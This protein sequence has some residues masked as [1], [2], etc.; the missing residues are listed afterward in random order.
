MHR[1]HCLVSGMVEAEQCVAEQVAG[2]CLNQVLAVVNNQ[3][4]FFSEDDEPVA[5][6]AVD[7]VVFPVPSPQAASRL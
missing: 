5:G 4:A 6:A 1:Q 3:R 2:D 7:E